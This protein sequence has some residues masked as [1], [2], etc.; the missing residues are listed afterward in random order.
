L[1]RPGR[2]HP[3]DV[4]A[5]LDRLA[6]DRPPIPWDTKVE[7]LL[8]GLRRP[9]LYAGRALSD[10]APWVADRELLETHTHFMGGS[11]CGK[12]A[13]GLASLAFQ[14]IAHADSSVVV[15]DL[16]GDNALFWGTFVE[17]RRAGLPF[18]WFTIEPGSASFSFNPF[19]QRVN[20]R[21]SLNARAQSLLVSLGLYFGEAYGKG[22]W[23]AI[24]L[25]TLTGF[26][27]RFKKIRSFADLARYAEEPGSYAAT[28]TSQEDSLHLRMLLRQ[29]AAVGPLNSSE[30]VRPDVPPEILRDAIDMTVVVTEPQVVYF[31][32]PSLE[33]ELT[34]KAVGKL[35]LYAIV[36]AAK[37]V[38][39]S[40]KSV[41][42][43]VFVDE[44]QQVC[45]E[46][47]KILLEM[48]RSNGVHL[49]LSHQDISQL[50]TA[51]YDITSTVESNTTFKLVFEA[52][53]LLALKQ[54]EEYSGEDTVRTPSWTQAVPP[55]LDEN[56]D[57][58]L[59]PERANPKRDFDPPTVDVSERERP[60]LTRN[61]I[62]SVS[63]HPLRGLVR[64]RS[65]CGLT[66]YG[67]QWTAIECEFPT[68]LAE[69]KA[70]AETPWP[71]DHPSCVTVSAGPGGEADDGDDEDGPAPA[72]P[73][74]PL[75]VPPPPRSVDRAIADRLRTL[76]EAIKT[77]H[78]RPPA[79]A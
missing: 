65:D 47:V 31:N 67:G 26:L 76:Q 71:S 11:R 35:A 6:P 66:Q 70:R 17:A 78:T 60:R 23:G 72:L 3:P 43:Y 5:T 20:Q 52:S 73:N 4:Q 9:H 51:D 25:D 40:R 46:N 18:R 68:T 33:E 21:R 45:A 64:S 10:G 62:L 53:S 19:A 1:I 58:A 59:S 61:E 13:L 2:P 55:G 27:A 15:I 8:N 56:D 12:T 74:D 16:K 69:Y 37:V 14:L 39:R 41:P 57:S 42:T 48:A 49:V 77:K 24:S 63:A 34:A 32:L 75:P 36:H 44:F 50:R 30:D 7:R 29:L 22:Y 79:G 28:N 54:M 38:R